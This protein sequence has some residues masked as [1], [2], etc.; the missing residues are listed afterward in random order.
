[1]GELRQR[2][3]VWW[4]RYYRN[5][6]RHEES[7][8]STKKG[9]AVDLLKVREGDVAKGLPVTA[10]AGQIRVEEALADVVTDYKVNGKRSLANVERRIKLHLES[11]FGGRRMAAITTADVTRYTAKRQGEGAANA[12]VNRELAILKRAFRLA[13]RGGTLLHR[14]YVP[15]LAEDNV[16]QGFFEDDQVASVLEHLPAE[17]RGVVRFAY[18]TGWRVPSE[19]LPLQWAQVDRK[20]QVVRLEPGVAKNREGRTLPYGALPDLV[21][22]IEG[23]WAE[24]KRLAST[25]VLCPWVFHRQGAPIRNFRKAWAT[26][27]KAAGLPGMLVHD[28]RRS[29]VRNLSRAGVPDTVAMKVSGHKTRSV[30]DRYNIVSEADLRVAIGR[31]SSAAGTEKGQ[32]APSGRVARFE[33]ST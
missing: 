12:S 18:F 3:K 19:V 6:C 16:R 22:V 14:P 32:S 5:G 27:T 15:M 21:G 23:A 4:I 26:A 25:G 10:K 31:L 9:A 20:A 8:R 7:S 1:M 33:Q 28:L 24:H 11:F 29:A 30:F 2:G 13:E 17:L